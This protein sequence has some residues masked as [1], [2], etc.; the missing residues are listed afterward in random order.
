MHQLHDDD[1]TSES[2]DNDIIKDGAKQ[3]F[4]PLYFLRFSPSADQK[5][6]RYGNKR[7]R[8]LSKVK[9]ELSASQIPG[10]V[11]S[12]SPRLNEFCNF[13]SA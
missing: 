13:H 1:D 3:E 11:V 8:S 2:E 5:S 4:L 6:E 10:S 7:E 12:K 9:W